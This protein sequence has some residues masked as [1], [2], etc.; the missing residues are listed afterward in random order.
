MTDNKKGAKMA[1][2][3]RK[4]ETARRT[5]Y[6]HRNPRVRRVSQNEW[7][8]KRMATFGEA[9]KWS[10]AAKSTRTA[11]GVTQREVADFYDVEGG[12]VAGWESG[13]YF[14]WTR[15][16]LVDYTQVCAELAEAQ[17]K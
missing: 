9:V 17:D 16:A 2:T 8:V 7:A 10:A 1:A 15:E 3:V 4:I 6:S 13:K 12:T 11:L 5:Q 14:G